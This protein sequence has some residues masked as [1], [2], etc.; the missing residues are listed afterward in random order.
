MAAAGV[1]PWYA[2]VKTE[3]EEEVLPG[4][5][6]IEHD[7]QIPPLEVCLVKE[8][9]KVE[10]TSEEEDE[11]SESWC[12]YSSHR[13]K[14]DVSEVLF[15]RWKVT[16]LSVLSSVFR[17]SAIPLAHQWG[18]INIFEMHLQLVVDAVAVPEGR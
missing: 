8:E 1:V 15:I 9:V 13:P 14:N 7:V 11:I 12:P 2:D 16:C 10:V 6:D 5:C 4:S 3:E 18:C 17:E